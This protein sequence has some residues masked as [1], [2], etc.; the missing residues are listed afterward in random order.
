[1][2]TTKRPTSRE[3]PSSGQSGTQVLSWIPARIRQYL[4][5]HVFSFPASFWYLVLSLIGYSSATISFIPMA[6]SFFESKYFPDDP[7]KASSYVSIP[8]VLSVFL[9]PLGG[10][11][12]DRKTPGANSQRDS[13][14]R[15]S[16]QVI[17]SGAC[18]TIAHLI[19]LLTD[20]NI[21]AGLMTLG[22]GYAGYGSVLYSLMAEVI[23]DPALLE[24]D[25]S[26]VQSP[27]SIRSPL[28][29]AMVMTMTGTSAA[30]STTDDVP[31]SASLITAPEDAEDAEEE[32]EDGKVASAYGISGCLFNG[33]FAAVP[34]LVA[35][36]MASAT[37]DAT[38]DHHIAYV[39]MEIF[40]SLTAGMGLIASVLARRHILMEQAQYATLR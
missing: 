5:V 28:G 19:F 1:M 3:A 32:E 15:K 10:Y 11:F 16:A 13:T 33:S 12:A 2:T 31:V 6:P 14:L 27:A 29:R 34:I 4:P 22:V 40:F 9:L 26:T 8:D 24:E 21:M 39:R 7:V 30:S 36:I 20:W 38:D 37:D 17:F 25:P 23:T 18:I 35:W